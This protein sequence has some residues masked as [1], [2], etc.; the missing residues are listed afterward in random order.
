M[1]RWAGRGLILFDVLVGVFVLS[2]GIVAVVGL[3]IQAGQAAKQLDRH[4]QAA[5]LAQD[6]IERLRNIGS[7]DWSADSLVTLTGSDNRSVDGVVFERII[8]FRPRP[9]LDAAGHLAEMEVQVRWQ[10][11][12]QAQSYSL[13]TYF[14]VDTGLE[15][16]R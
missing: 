11:H 9:D 6:A 2:V 15:N 8:N 3:F 14:A 5:C 4:E 12:G 13:L 10:E 7:E 16:L 1:K